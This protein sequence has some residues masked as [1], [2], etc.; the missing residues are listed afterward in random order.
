MV[1]G[2]Q[3]TKYPT[4]RKGLLYPGD[5][6]I[7]RTL[8]RTRYNTFAPRLG[9][10]WSPNMSEGLLGKIVG[11]PGKT[12]IRLGSGMFYTAIQDQTLYWILG[13]VPFGEYWASPSPTLFEEPFR[14]RA[15][16]ASQGQ[17]FP[18]IIPA[19]GSDAAKNFNFS[20]YLPLV[21]TLGYETHNKLP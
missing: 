1:P 6:G 8:A 14:T 10:A 3:S 20:P 17:P 15:T 13:T 9:I 12:S 7:R 19:P 21:S 4:A 16:G 5:A 2:Q 11:R 18:Y